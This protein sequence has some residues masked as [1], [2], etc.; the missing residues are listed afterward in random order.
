MRIAS[1]YL[2]SLFVD[3]WHKSNNDSIEYQG[4]PENQKIDKNVFFI[5][6]Y[7]A[8]GLSVTKYFGNA[9]SIIELFS[10]N[11]NNGLKLWFEQVFMHSQNAIFNQKIW[12]I[13]CIVLVY[14]IIPVIITKFV[15]K[16]KLNEFGFSF[17][18]VL[19]DYPL[20]L[21]MLGIMLPLV[22][23]ASKTQSFQARYP[24][25]KPNSSNLL[26]LFIYWQIAYFI[27]FIAVEFFF[28]G[29]IIHGLKMR[30]GFYAVLISTIPYC[31]VHFGKPFGETVAAIV[32]GLVLG[33]LSL[34]SRS[35]ILGVLIHYSVAI[36]M[37]LFALYQSGLI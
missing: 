34:K 35:V 37:D 15:F 18:N 13:S 2:R 30:F 11:D 21:L 10:K 7:I 32:A 3:N 33:S 4:K 6:T 28:R 9:Y 5:L 14:L 17:N 25:F 16:R 1:S 12:W 8:F 26:P 36:T 19:K 20:Y 23:F 31:M 22:Y 27:Q 24:I 29:F